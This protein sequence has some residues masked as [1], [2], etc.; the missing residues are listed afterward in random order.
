[1][2]TDD[3]IVGKADFALQ[4][5]RGVNFWTRHWANSLAVRRSK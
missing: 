3:D 5:R 1:V 4:D 2:G